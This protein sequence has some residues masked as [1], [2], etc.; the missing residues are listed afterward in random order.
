MLLPLCARTYS[1]SFAALAAYSM[2]GYE[3]CEVVAVP[4]VLAPFVTRGADVEGFSKP[5]EFGMVG[6][7][8]TRA[9]AA[10]ARSSTRVWGGRSCR[11]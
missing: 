2:L 11:A 6:L 10:W 3:P 5:A 7:S 4:H 8:G 9:A 1:S